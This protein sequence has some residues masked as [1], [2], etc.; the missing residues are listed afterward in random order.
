M[1]KRKIIENLSSTQM[2]FFILRGNRH[3]YSCL[4]TMKYMRK[5]L[6]HS[7]EM[8]LLK[9]TLH[10]K[11]VEMSCR[12]LKFRISCVCNNAFETLQ[13]NNYYN[14]N[15]M[16]KNGNISSLQLSLRYILLK[17]VIISKCNIDKQGFWWTV[18]PHTSVKSINILVKKIPFH[19][20]FL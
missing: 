1:T 14:Q 6:I 11:T 12:L 15:K 7:L 8:F 5:I 18:L 4:N 17:I 3:F 16:N 2:I 9:S 13:N 10:L 20:L 19:V